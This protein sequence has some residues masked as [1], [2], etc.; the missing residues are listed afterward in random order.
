MLIPSIRHI[1]H[2]VVPHPS[3]LAGKEPFRCTRYIHSRRYNRAKSHRSITL[4]PPG[5][6]TDNLDPGTQLLAN[7]AYLKNKSPLLIKN[8]LLAG[9]FIDLLPFSLHACIY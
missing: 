6:E 7:G 8:T 2:E 3:G 5:A 9:A 1:A 4:A